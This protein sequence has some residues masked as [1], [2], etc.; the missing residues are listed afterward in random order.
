MLQHWITKVRFVNRSPQLKA[1]HYWRL[2]LKG[3]DNSSNLIEAVIALHGPFSWSWDSKWCLFSQ[4]NAVDSLAQTSIQQA[5]TNES[6]QNGVVVFNRT[7]EKHRLINPRKPK[8]QPKYSR[9]TASIRNERIINDHQAKHSLAKVLHSKQALTNESC[10]MPQRLQ[11][12]SWV[13]TLVL[14]PASLD[15]C[16]NKNKP[17]SF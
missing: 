8:W 6:C 1:L 17:I 14:S 7:Q 3:P 2:C 9:C 13:D 12:S 4:K 5:L 11:H 10:Q 16:A 15:A